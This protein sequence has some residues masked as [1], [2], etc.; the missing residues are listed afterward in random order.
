[1]LA[2]ARARGLKIVPL[3]SYIVDY[4]NRHPEERDVLADRPPA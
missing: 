3:C 4:F 2:D 1:M